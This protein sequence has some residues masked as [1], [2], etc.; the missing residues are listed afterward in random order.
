M[1]K[2]LFEI[3]SR[4]KYR[5]A[6]RGMIS[7]ED[8][9]DLRL[10]SLDEIYKNLSSEIKKAS[11]E[12]LLKT[13]TKDQEVIENKIEIVKY[14]VNVKLQEVESRRREIEN[15]EKKQHIMAILSQKEDEDLKNKSIEELK[16]MISEL[17]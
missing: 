5:F 17:E 13:K 6:Y 1:E 8:L 2:N 4:C 9:W 16:A 7:V 12:S 3:A 14:I 11:E 15:K 10:E